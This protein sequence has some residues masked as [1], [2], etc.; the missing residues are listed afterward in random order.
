MHF[1][2]VP[3]YLHINTSNYCHASPETPVLG[4]VGQ[5]VLRTS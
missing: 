3:M 1:N 5:L 4:H 2:Y